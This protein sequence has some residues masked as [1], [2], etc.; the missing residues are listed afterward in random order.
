[1]PVLWPRGRALAVVQPLGDT[2]RLD[3]RIGKF[4]MCHD[5]N[6]NCVLQ[7]SQ[8]Q[9]LCRVCRRFAK[10]CLCMRVTLC[11]RLAA[12][13]LWLPTVR[14][15]GCEPSSVIADDAGFVAHVAVDKY[16]VIP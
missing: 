15:V 14:Q 2:S 8:S 11:G 4:A 13:F 9:V 5:R 16:A 1:M 3:R 10:V 7:R 6:A 12:A